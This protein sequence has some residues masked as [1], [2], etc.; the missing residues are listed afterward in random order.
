MDIKALKTELRNQIKEET[1]ALPE[2]YISDSDNGLLL[3]VTSMKEFSAAGNIMIYY[4]VEKEP[5]THN[6]AEAA[7]H[8]GKTVAFPFCR[9]GGTMQARVVSDLGELAPSLL[10]IPAPPET[11]PLIEPD[12]L[13]LIIVPALAYD[14]YGCRIGYGG[15]YYDRYLCGIQAFTVGLAR[16]RLMKETVPREPHDIAVK[17]LVTENE[18][19]RL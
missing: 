19:M 4:S 2:D 8:A 14:R 1:A 5:D 13:D 9:R 6:I 17:C 11:A 3:L 12:E 15:G 18:I 16:E 7:L 10:S